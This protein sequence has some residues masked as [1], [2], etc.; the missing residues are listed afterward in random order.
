MIILNSTSTLTQSQ[1]QINFRLNWISNQPQLNINN[2]LNSIWLWHKGN[3]ILYRIYF[4]LSEAEYLNRNQLYLEY[5]ARFFLQ[6]EDDLYWP[7]NSVTSLHFECWR[8]F[9]V[10]EIKWITYCR[11]RLVRFE[12][13]KD[14]DCSNGFMAPV[15]VG[16]TSRYHTHSDKLWP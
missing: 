2:N 15:N 14:E 5:S 12:L 9:S 16:H 1:P 6:N 13:Q 4:T 7:W 3:P 10:S 8:Y 11:N